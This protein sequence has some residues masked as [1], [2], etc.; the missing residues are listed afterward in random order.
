MKPHVAQNSGDNE[1]YT[2]SSIITSALAVMGKVDLDPAS[3]EIANKVV[4]ARVFYNISDDG[5]SKL[6]KGKVWMNPPYAQ[7][8]ASLFCKKLIYH[9]KEG[10]VPEATAL[11]NN[12]T[13]TKW[14]QELASAASAICFP[15]G[16]IR[17][18]HPDK[19]TSTPLQGQAVFYF[20]SNIEVFV[21]I[22]K[23]HGSCFVVL[24]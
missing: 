4:K 2:P 13:E 18:W 6:W 20:G 9:F 23:L 10:D 21:N 5:L 17:Y 15:K 22:F 16:R 24:A 14:F 19:K 8:L 3:S 7:P 11:L 12:A 1:W